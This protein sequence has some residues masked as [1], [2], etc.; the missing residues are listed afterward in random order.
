MQKHCEFDCAEYEILL[1]TEVTPS[2]K[3]IK[4]IEEAQLLITG[5]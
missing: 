4:Q 1:I 5:H 3:K 2:E